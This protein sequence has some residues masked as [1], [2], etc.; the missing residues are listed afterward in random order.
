MIMFVC[1][2]SQLCAGTR[3]IRRKIIHFSPVLVIRVYEH[4]MHSRITTNEVVQSR[5]INLGSVQY[6]LAGITFH[7][8]AHFCAIVVYADELYWYDGLKGQLGD[9]P[10]DLDSWF[11]CHAVYCQQ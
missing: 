6:A 1:F 9:V 10:D 3:T 2:R 8:N 11:P 4:C 7:R 5:H